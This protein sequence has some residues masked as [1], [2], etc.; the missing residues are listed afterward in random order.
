MTA[1]VDRLKAGVEADFGPA[2]GRRTA[3]DLRFFVIY[4]IY[5]AARGKT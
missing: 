5:D 4:D 2:R 1:V 3:H